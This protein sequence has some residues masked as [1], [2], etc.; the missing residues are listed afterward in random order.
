MI[1]KSQDV[2]SLPVLSDRDSKQVIGMITDRDIAVRVVAEQRD[3]YNTHVEDVMSKDVV[4]CRTDD[5]YDEVVAAMKRRQIRRVPVVDSQNRLAGIIG[6]AD[7][8]RQA[9][10]PEVVGK[11]VERIS[12][13]GPSGS[14]GGQ[15]GAYTKTG[16]L[17]AGGLGIGA[18]LIYLLDPRWARRARESVANAAGSM[19]ESVENAAG[20]VR[21]RVSDVAENVR[22]S[23]TSTA[24]SLRETVGH[25]QGGG[26]GQQQQ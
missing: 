8:A 22:Q 10:E 5:D 23:V 25:F 2:G 19:R 16:L 17:I 11:T 20:S 12:Q 13:P 6:L 14:Q 3:Y 26:D 15:R 1:M 7:V 24:D 18:G 21:D 9:P 4:T